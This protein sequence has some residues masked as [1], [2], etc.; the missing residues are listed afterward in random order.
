M[1]IDLTDDE[2]RA[3]VQLLHRTIDFDPYPLAPRLA[4]LQA[5]LDKLDPPP[6]RPEPRPPLPAGMRL[7]VGRGKRR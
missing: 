6:P 5:I 7:R 3:L 4:P 1:S 2:R